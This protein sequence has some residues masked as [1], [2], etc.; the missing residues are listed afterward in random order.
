MFD[1][2]SEETVIVCGSGA[3]HRKTAAASGRAADFMA[4]V[5]KSR[6]DNSDGQI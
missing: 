2:A 4:G 3:R 5:Q 6:M 1:S